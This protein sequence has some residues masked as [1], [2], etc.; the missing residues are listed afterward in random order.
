MKEF[1]RNKDK[2]AGTS[3]GCKSVEEFAQRIVENFY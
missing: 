3:L 2:K 1:N